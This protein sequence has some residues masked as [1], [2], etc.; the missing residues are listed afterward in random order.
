MDLDRAEISKCQ[1]E[2]INND[3]FALDNKNLSNK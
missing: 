1:I 3:F 2:N